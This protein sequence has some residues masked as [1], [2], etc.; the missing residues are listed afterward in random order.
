MCLWVRNQA[1]WFHPSSTG[2]GSQHIACGVAAPMCLIC[3]RLLP[4]FASQVFLALLKVDALADVNN[5]LQ[6]S[7]A[8]ATSA[9][10]GERAKRD[11][12]HKQVCSLS[13]CAHLLD[14]KCNSSSLPHVACQKVPGVLPG[15]VLPGPV[16][17][18]DRQHAI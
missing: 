4:K 13:W 3:F 2:L 16:P 15:S 1:A 14:S 12:L 17:D 8:E 11:N 5:R 10:R 6:A 9:C 18:S 7:L